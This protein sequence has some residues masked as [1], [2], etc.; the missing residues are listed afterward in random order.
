[1]AIDPFEE[2]LGLTSEQIAELTPLRKK[3]RPRAS[4]TEF[5]TLPYEQILAAAGQVGSAHLAV[6]VE[7]AHRR[8]RRHQ[9]PI[10]LASKALE[11]VGITHGPNIAL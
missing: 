4:P 8:F 10:P 3:R 9:N 1:M 11:A 6:L 7:I 5:V 2:S